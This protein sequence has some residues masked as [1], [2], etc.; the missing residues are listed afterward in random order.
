MVWKTNFDTSSPIGEP[1]NFG[2]NRYASSNE[3]ATSDYPGTSRTSSAYVPPSTKSQISSLKEKSQ[4]ETSDE[5]RA[6]K[7]KLDRFDSIL[8]NNTSR[9][10]F[11][12]K[13]DI[14]NNK[15]DPRSSDS[16][17]Q[18]EITNIGPGY[19][20]GIARVRRIFISA[21]YH[22]VVRS[23]LVNKCIC[24]FGQFNNE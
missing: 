7:V 4:P 14:F 3:G 23:C 19:E 6:R 9:F 1:T 11:H 5:R 21:V 24:L 15:S 18:L 2:V 12:L 8:S 22:L 13:I 20:N 17:D 16:G 10:H